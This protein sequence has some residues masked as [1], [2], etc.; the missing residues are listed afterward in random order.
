LVGCAAGTRPEVVAE[1]SAD[2]VADVETW[3][4]E[5]EASLRREDGWLTLVGLFWLEEGR[6]TFGSDPASDLVFPAGTPPQLGEF[7]LEEGVVTLRAAEGSAIGHGGGPV[8]EMVLQP[9]S[10]G[11]P[12]ILELGSL[13][14]YAIDRVGRFGIRVKDREAEDLRTFKGMDYY[15][16]DPSWRIEARFSAFE[17]PKTMQVPNFVGTAFEE[18]VPG[19]VSFE[20]DGQRLELTPVGEVGAPLFFVFGDTTNGGDT[21][22]GGRFL[23]ADW[24]TEDGVVVLDFNRAYN[25]P[26]VFSPYATCP[27]PPAENKLKLAVEAGELV[28]GQGH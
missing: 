5:R 3:K 28:Y 21:Y 18:P 11:D 20:R 19:V 4:K 17:E 25:P 22:G 7:L 27:L 14:F 13:T 10:T 1:L 6:N 2:Y 12:T 8:S 26:C 16:L 23:Y 15:P 9:D 24:P